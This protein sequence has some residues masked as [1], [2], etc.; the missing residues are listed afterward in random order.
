MAQALKLNTL[1]YYLNIAQKIPSIHLEEALYTYRNKN[2]TTIF[3]NNNNLGYYLAGLLEGDG[4]ISLPS[5]G[6]TS[7]NRVLN[8][9]IVF[10]SHINNIGMY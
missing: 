2:N 10:T 9:R 6:V 8:P 4:S 5:L 7:L 3:T 1:N